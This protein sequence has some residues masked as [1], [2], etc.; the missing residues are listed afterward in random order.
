[1]RRSFLAFAVVLPLVALVLGIVRSEQRLAEGRRW[2]F[3]VT[4]YDPRDLLRGHYIQYR[5]VL[6]DTDLP[7]LGA[8]DGSSCDD[9]TGDF[10]CL[11]L[12][13]DVENDKTYVERTACQLAR[14]E[15]EGMLQL[16]YLGELER[17]YIA[18]ERAEELTAIFQDAARDNR[19]R[20]IVAI[21]A[22]GKPQIDTLLVNDMPVEQARPAV[23]E[24][25]A[26]AESADAGSTS[27]DSGTAP[28]DP[29]ER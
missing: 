20:L 28:A 14:T 13:A 15:C 22:E 5:L 23:R 10:C 1:M 19:A 12:L 26:P 16:R 11:C 7:V 24:P 27:P 29:Q 6:E 2:S 18:E 17:Y 3:E 8:G 25:T 21:D 4:G 9:E